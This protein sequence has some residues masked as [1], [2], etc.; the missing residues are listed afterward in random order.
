MSYALDGVSKNIEYLI[1]FGAVYMSFVLFLS[2]DVIS[3]GTQIIQDTKPLLTF[4]VVFYWCV[5][6]PTLIPLW[7]AFAMG[8]IIDIYSGYPLGLNALGFV[9]LRSVIAAQRRLF[10]GQPF[11]SILLGFAIAVTLF[12]ALQCGIMLLLNGTMVFLMPVALKVISAISIFPVFILLMKVLH[13]LLPDT[14]ATSIKQRGAQ[15]LK[16]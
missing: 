8:I 15:I 1:R 4:A 3:Y 5:Y 7:L 16:G 11:A 2:L 14:N 13:R 10:L 12:Y 6:R 9:I